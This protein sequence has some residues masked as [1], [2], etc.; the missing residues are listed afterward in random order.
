MFSFSSKAAG[1]AKRLGCLMVGG[2]LVGCQ[3]ESFNQAMVEPSSPVISSGETEEV[4]T[5]S[6]SLGAGDSI[7]FQ[8]FSSA[9]VSRL[10]VEH[11]LVSADQSE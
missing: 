7:G 8:L 2:L 10:G 11:E 3:C 5:G 1:W 6:I 9:S 4:A